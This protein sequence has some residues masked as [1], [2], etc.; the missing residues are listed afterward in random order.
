MMGTHQM[1][2]K[3]VLDAMLAE[4]IACVFSEYVD[5]HGL[6]DIASIFAKGVRIEVGDTLPSAHYESTS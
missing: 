2:E 4:A 3:Q 1:T 6:G 5:E